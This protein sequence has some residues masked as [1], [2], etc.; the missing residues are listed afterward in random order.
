M[1]FTF[2]PY[3]IVYGESIVFVQIF[4]FEF[5]ADISILVPPVS[6]KVVFRVMSV[7]V[8]LSVCLCVFVCVGGMFKRPET[9][10]THLHILVHNFIASN[11]IKIWSEFYE[12]WYV[13]NNARHLHALFPF[14]FY[15][16]GFYP[17]KI[18]KNGSKDVAVIKM[19]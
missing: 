11:F 10:T 5:L 1:L 12:I 9:H 6:K 3:T 17:P 8:C 2:L 14:L 18:P 7:C 16:K 15:F 4:E 19:L 13:D